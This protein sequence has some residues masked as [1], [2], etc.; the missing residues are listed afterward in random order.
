MR[1]LIL[2]FLRLFKVI[3]VH[4]VFLDNAVLEINSSIPLFAWAHL[5]LYMK[6][7]RV[8]IRL[9]IV[10]LWGNRVVCFG[11]CVGYFGGDK[12]QKAAALLAEVSIDVNGHVTALLYQYLPTSR[13]RPRASPS[14]RARAHGITALMRTAHRLKC[15]PPALPLLWKILNY[16]FKMVLGFSDCNRLL[17]T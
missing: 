17:P 12:R 5:L 10:R 7:G 15:V 8:V 3:P 13:D 9:C 1:S 6:H 16:N 14:R 4:S 11:S 2:S